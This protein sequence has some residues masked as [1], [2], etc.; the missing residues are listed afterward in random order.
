MRIGFLRGKNAV[1]SEVADE[2]DGG[3]L[4]CPHISTETKST[5][6]RRRAT[7]TRDILSPC[8]SLLSNEYISHLV[9]DISTY[10]LGQV[11][12]NAYPKDPA[13]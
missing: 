5:Q 7:L 1:R 8:H 2:P 13:K 9:N 11:P 3:W 6:P 12:N 4:G 10:D